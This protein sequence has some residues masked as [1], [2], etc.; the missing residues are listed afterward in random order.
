MLQDLPDDAA[1]D[2][3]FEVD[4]HYP[5]RL[6]DRHDDYP[7]TLESSVSDRSMY[8]STQQTVFPEATPQRKLTPNFRDKV[9]YEVHYRNLKLYLQSST[10]IS[11]GPFSKELLRI[12]EQQRIHMCVKYTRAAQLRDYCSRIRIF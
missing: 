10:F 1:D 9:K 2:Y 4:L 7:L 6:H 5:T 12:G 3:I 11:W 8:S